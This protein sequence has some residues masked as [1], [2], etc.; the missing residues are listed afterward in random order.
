MVYFGIWK[1]LLWS[2]RRIL[3]IKRHNLWHLW[4]LEGPERLHDILST[5]YLYILDLSATW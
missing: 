3:V 2:C 5:N 1:I 4:I